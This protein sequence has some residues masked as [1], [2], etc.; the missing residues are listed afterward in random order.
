[1]TLSF[2][3]N[4]ADLKVWVVTDIVWHDDDCGNREVHSIWFSKEKAEA[5]AKECG[6]RAE[7]QECTEGRF[8]A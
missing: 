3:V 4:T 2:L 6:F 5:A 7:V 8:W 1:M